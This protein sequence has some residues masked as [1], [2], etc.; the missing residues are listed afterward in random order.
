ME[1]I[2]EMEHLP[3]VE[4]ERVICFVRD[5][6]RPLSGDELSELAGKLVEES[7]PTRIEGLKERIAA[8]FYGDR[9]NT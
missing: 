3:P 4:R 5:L 2:N 9:R 6:E 7:D 1:I 8:G